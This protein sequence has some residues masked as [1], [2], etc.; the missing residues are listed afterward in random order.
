MHSCSPWRRNQTSGRQT[1]AGSGHG[2]TGAPVPSKSA[3]ASS[4]PVQTITVAFLLQSPDRKKA[5]TAQRTFDSEGE[6]NHPGC[7]IAPFDFMPQIS[8]S[9]SP[10]PLF[11]IGVP[12]RRSCTRTTRRR[13]YT[14]TQTRS[15][16]SPNPTKTSW[17]S[18]GPFAPPGASSVWSGRT[19]TPSHISPCITRSRFTPWNARALKNAVISSLAAGRTHPPTPAAFLCP[20]CC[21]SGRTGAVVLVVGGQGVGQIHRK[22]RKLSW[23]F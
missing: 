8:I 17:C 7:A 14:M 22:S 21:L 16:G 18:T 15:A 2:S 19:L 23:F 11:C 13:P 20:S 6:S 12:Q 10:P 4:G 3:S 9:F 5:L 1:R